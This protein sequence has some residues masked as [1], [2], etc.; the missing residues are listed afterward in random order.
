MN[1]PRRGK[2]AAQGRAFEV[3]AQK[4]LGIVGALILD[5]QRNGAIEPRARIGRSHRFA[6]LGH[7]RKRLRLALLQG[8]VAD[9]VEKLD[10]FGMQFQSLGE[11]G[12]SGCE[13]LFLTPA[14]S[15]RVMALGGIER[16][17]LGNFRARLVFTTAGNARSA[18]IKLN[19][20]LVG[21]KVF[22]V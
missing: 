3:L 22:F 15:R 12:V 19:E 5:D 7:D 11:L 4:A 2:P 21:G 17:K 10:R 16:R 8:V 18:A 6:L 1:A 20:R 9:V 14:I 13:V